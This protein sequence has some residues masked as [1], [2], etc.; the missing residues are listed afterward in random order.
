MVELLRYK[1]VGRGSVPGEVI[2]FINLHDFSIRTKV[3]R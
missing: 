2:G 3:L 1:P